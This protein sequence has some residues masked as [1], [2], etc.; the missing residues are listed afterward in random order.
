MSDRPD[1]TAVAATPS[2]DGTQLPSVDEMSRDQMLD[3]FVRVVNVVEPDHGY[4]QSRD[5]WLPLT[6]DR[7]EYGWTKGNVYA[8]C[9]PRNG[10]YH[11]LFKI[12]ASHARS[13]W[14]TERFL[15]VLVHEL[16]HLSIGYEYREAVHPPMFW[17]DYAFYAWELLDEWDVVQSWF[18]TDVSREAFAD[19]CLDDP[20]DWMVDG[21]SETVT[22][23]RERMYGYLVNA[24]PTLG[25]PQ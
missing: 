4:K 19:G 22:G 13:W 2:T 20:N 12:N 5:D 8:R 17:T 14:S 25:E 24:V 18:T 21:R 1:P 11:A 16:T 15:A 10:R 23:V 3:T 7:V 6:E 9:G